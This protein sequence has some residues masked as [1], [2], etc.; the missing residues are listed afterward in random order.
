MLYFYR[1]KPS[2]LAGHGEQPTFGGVDCDDDGPPPASTSSP[3]S[4]ITI[5][6]LS[7]VTV[8]ISAF[9]LRKI[10]LRFLRSASVLELE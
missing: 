8:L 9:A 3:S 7:G 10:V 6:T 5:W 4:M 2:Q 1:G